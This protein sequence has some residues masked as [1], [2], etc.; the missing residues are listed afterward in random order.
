MAGGDTGI[1]ATCPNCGAAEMHLL[2]T[3]HLE[4]LSYQFFVR[5]SMFSPGYGAAPVIQFNE[6]QTGC[7][8]AAGRLERDIDLLQRTLGVGFFYYGP[9]LWM[10]GEIE[11]LKDL[12]RKRTRG[13]TIRRILA[14]FPE[15]TIAP[16][17][18]FFRVRKAP[19][20]PENPLEYDSPPSQLS[21][22]GRLDTAENPILYGSQDLEICVHESR[23][24]ANDELFVSTQTPKRVMRLLDLTAIL[25]EDCDEFESLDL[26]V[27][28]LFLAG[29]HSY[30][31][32]REI[33]SAAAKAGFDGLLYPS[34]FSMLRTGGVPFETAYGLSLR[35]FGDN[36]FEKS[37]IISNLALFGRP[38]A[39]G[40]VDIVGINR[41]VITT[42]RYGMSL[43]P[44]GL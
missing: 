20:D 33:A 22:G 32:S 8:E 2:T 1:T 42:V 18:E 4:D 9:R 17:M 10:V 29:S 23:F 6:H 24:T 37:K 5:G 41:L 28:M 44:V 39:Q 3:G 36:N 27:N 16:G 35:R 38:I 26:A 21:G 43:G 19:N 11:P 25:N 13:K 34:F 15:V 7:L 31:I 40:D 30:P 14:E 12:Q